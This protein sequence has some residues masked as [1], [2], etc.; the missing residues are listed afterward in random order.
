M[1]QDPKDDLGF[2]LPEPARLSPTRAIAI[3]AV[4]LTVLAGGFIVGWL[5]RHRDK[6]ALE[7]ETKDAE[8][9]MPRVVVFTPKVMTSDRAL[10]LPGSV[11]PLEET[12]V[13]PR[14]SGYVRKWLVDI[15]DKVAEG[16]VLAEIDTP[17]L[18]QQLA[19]ARAQLAQ[20]EAGL[21]QAQASSA[22]SKTNAERYEK[23]APAGVASQQ[24]LDKEKAQA[25]VNEANV[26]VAKANVTAQK[27]NIERL[28]QMKQ[29]AHV[30]AP[31]AGTIT[32][33]T[34]DRGALV[35]AGNTTPLFKLAATDPVRVFVQ[36]PQDAAT[37]IKIGA[38]ARV[39][40]REFAGRTFEGQIAH[41]AGALDSATRTMTTEVRVPN[42]NGEILSGMYAQVALTLPTPHRVLEIPATALV[43]DAKGV[44]VATVSSAGTIHLVP[45]VVERDTGATIEIAS[46]LDGTERVVKLASVELVEGRAVE[47]AKAEK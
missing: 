43:N 21:V 10:M 22:Y 46:G 9:A 24:E 5:P 37:G 17:E 8:V 15:G 23:L 30:T 2:A 20:A 36:V 12:V 4:V 1:S 47:V 31:F 7:A 6:I 38:A 18:D 14:A 41:S 11:Q 35:S 3:G 19:Q 28:A 32:S 33:R 29:F 25:T 39:T 42:P 34:I 16:A 44:R 13:Y 26:T 40:V 27:A 45:V